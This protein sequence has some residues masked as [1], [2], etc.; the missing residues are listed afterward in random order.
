MK[1]SAF[2]IVYQIF[3]W[4]HAAGANHF[5]DVEL[6]AE[7]IEDCRTKVK[8]AAA[9]RLESELHQLNLNCLSG[10]QSF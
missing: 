4:T 8:S 6:I 3:S 10:Q 2:W 5:K 7:S 9:N 1:V